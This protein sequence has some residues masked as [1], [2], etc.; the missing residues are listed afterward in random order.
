MRVEPEEYLALDLRAHGLLADV[1]LHDVWAVDLEGLA[2]D[3][4]MLDLREL[5]SLEA[6]TKINPA[7]R[8]LFGLRRLMGRFSSADRAPPRA[9]E[10]SYVAR[11]TDADRA[12]TLVAPGTPESIFQV[13]YVFPT[14]LVGEIQNATVHAFSA[15]ALQARP[16][17]YRLYWAIYVQPVGRIT[18]WYMRLIDPFRR[19]VIYPSVLRY[20]RAAWAR[21]ARPT[22][23]P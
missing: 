15:Y 7:V 16:G 10:S 11:L 2:S 9:S 1:P 18:S 14:E 4:P 23:R 19:L 3:R 13:L 6:L 12:A 20:V 8:L 17:G 21:G 5:L 22:E